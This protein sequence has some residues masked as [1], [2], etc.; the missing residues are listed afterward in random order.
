M[1]RRTP[2]ALV[3][4]SLALALAVTTVGLTGCKSG[5]LPGGIKAPT[6][7]AVPAQAKGLSSAGASANAKLEPSSCKWG[8]SVEGIKLRAFLQATERLQAEVDSTTRLVLNTCRDLGRA[9]DIP[10][11]ELQGETKPVCDRV[12][13]GIRAHMQVG[14]KADAKMV[15]EARPA[16][17]RVDVE[18]AAEATAACEGKASADVQ[19][20][21]EGSCT[22]TCKGECDGTC[23]AKGGA[24][25]KASAK[26][27]Q[28]GAGGDASCN[29]KCEGTCRGQCSG[30]CSG[31]ADVDASAECRA[32]ARVRAS[33]QAKCEPPKVTVTIKAKAMADT[34]KA[35][36]LQ[37]ALQKHLPELFAVRA[38]VT[39]PIQGAFE[40][41]ADT[42]R[43]LAGAGPR[44]ARSFGDQA[45]CVAGQ[46][47]AAAR[48]ASSIE[49][50]MSVSVEASASV[51]GAAGASAG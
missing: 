7:P 19:V 6:A 2:F 20:R 5:S 51:S 48:A 9:L 8:G 39:G 22:G 43:D 27:S 34:K 30:G 42:A 1:H 4:S 23:Q 10:A 46:L 3:L 14:L 18:A 33:V 36:Q 16:Q 12:A 45:A 31:H 44:V 28:G 47:S 49:V 24:R 17:C 11:G 38:R 13:E 41:W 50:N 26:G 15:V 40:V 32:S 29:G 25:G 37:R 35:K 21:C